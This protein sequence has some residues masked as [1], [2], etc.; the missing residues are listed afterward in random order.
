MRRVTRHIFSRVKKAR[1]WQRGVRFC[2][3]Q[4]RE[5]KEVPSE[6]KK[7]VKKPVKSQRV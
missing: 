4:I 3:E 2:E 6:T 5:N 7:S 1:I